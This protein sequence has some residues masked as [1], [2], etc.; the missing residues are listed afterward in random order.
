M[1]ILPHFVLPKEN[2]LLTLGDEID[3][4]SNH[5][6]EISPSNSCI[7]EF[8]KASPDLSTIDF[9]S[10]K[11]LQLSTMK[12]KFGILSGYHSNQHIYDMKDHN[13]QTN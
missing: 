9:N 7:E 1:A 3:N 11:Y 5:L 13:K 2:N 8:I 10:K 6:D 4:K 12:I